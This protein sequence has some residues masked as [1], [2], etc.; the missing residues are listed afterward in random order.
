MAEYFDLGEM[1]FQKI[2][3]G[4]VQVLV[5]SV[6]AGAHDKR[7]YIWPMPKSVS[8]GSGI[9]YLSDVLVLKVEGSNY[10]DDSTG[11]LK[12]G[13]SRIVDTITGT[14]GHIVEANFSNFD[15]SQVIKGIH[16]VVNSPDYEV[17]IQSLPFLF[18]IL[19][20]VC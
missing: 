11:I 2:Y 10:T 16:I 8:Y 1:S 15:P 14:G 20:L 3:I 19:F 17:V 5:L 13:F 4:V 12:E 9:L 7:L 6:A 18:L